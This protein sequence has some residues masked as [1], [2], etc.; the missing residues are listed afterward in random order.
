MYQELF[1]CVWRFTGFQPKRKELNKWAYGSSVGTTFLC[2]EYKLGTDMSTKYVLSVHH[3]LWIIGQNTKCY[4]TTQTLSYWCHASIFHA[5]A[6]KK[7]D[8]QERGTLYKIGRNPIL[9]W[10]YT[11]H[12]VRQGLWLSKSFITNYR[13]TVRD[14]KK[15]VDMFCTEFGEDYM[16]YVSKKAKHVSHKIKNGGKNV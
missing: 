4:I 15:R 16:K 9:H 6:H 13:Q 5:Y 1:I 3:I 12:E 10:R 2:V 7:P 8:N 11:A 14:V